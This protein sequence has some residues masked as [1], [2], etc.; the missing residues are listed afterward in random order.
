MATETI[1]FGGNAPAQ[2]SVPTLEQAEAQ[3]GGPRVRLINLDTTSPIAKCKS[4]TSEQT[5]TAI[6]TIDGE[7]NV[8]GITCDCPNGRSRAQALCW[9]AAALDL[10]IDVQKGEDEL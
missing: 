4:L 8:A 2:Y 3:L 5:W 6:A 9:H 1:N 7:G 10:A